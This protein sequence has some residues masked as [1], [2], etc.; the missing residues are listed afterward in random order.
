MECRI[1]LAIM[2]CGAAA[3]AIHIPVLK[4]LVDQFEIVAIC[5]NILERASFTSSYF[6][7][8]RYFGS[9]DEMLN[10]KF[11]MLVI[12]TLNHEEAIDKALNSNRH[13]FTEKPIS[14][15]IAHSQRLIEKAKRKGL[16]LEVGLMRLYDP[17]MVSLK[18]DFLMGK[19]T[20]AIFTKYDGND[21]HMRK[22]ILP[23]NFELYTFA[24]SPEPI[25]PKGLS[26]DGDWALKFLLW[27]GIHLLTCICMVYNS[28][29]AT[30]TYTNAVKTSLSCLLEVENSHKLIL[31]ITQTDL[32][33]YIERAE[34][35]F[36]TK[37]S[38]VKF[39]SPY[40]TNAKTKLSLIKEHAGKTQIT[41][42]HAATTAFTSMWRS[43]SN[44]L[45]NKKG[46]N[47][48]ASLDLALAVEKLARAL[49]EL[50]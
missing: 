32:P 9:L 8:S 33:I 42:T 39:C 48:F 47:N 31:N 36:P 20:A 40:L 30:A 15:D 38:I 19:T 22:S 6:G 34:F 28:I 10:E 13:V 44:K 26:K 25:L 12:L 50:I 14:L 18:D 11:D 45:E 43:I 3:F 41:N 35:I 21:R 24:K 49:A 37:I 7:I 29:T 1:K 16:V 46:V 27:S 5:D 2:G 23:N 17:I 4:R